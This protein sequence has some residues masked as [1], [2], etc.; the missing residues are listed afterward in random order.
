MIGRRSGVVSACLMLAVGFAVAVAPGSTAATHAAPPVAQATTGRVWATIS[1]GDLDTCGIR[2]DHTLWCWGS[3]HF[4]QL[5]LG[6]IQDR[7][8]PT[9]VGTDTDWA[10]I[11]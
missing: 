5:G 8:V 9:Q 3:N 6:D 1:A 11:T 2:R 10:A 4:G 7:H